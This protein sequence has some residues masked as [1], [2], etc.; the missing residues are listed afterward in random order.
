MLQRFGN[1]PTFT[2]ALEYKTGINIKFKCVC[3]V[4]HFLVIVLL[5]LPM[6]VLSSKAYCKVCNVDI[7]NLDGKCYH[8]VLMI[9]LQ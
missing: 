9:N 4:I 1:P 6:P 3:V 7:Y 8:Q 2:K 5:V